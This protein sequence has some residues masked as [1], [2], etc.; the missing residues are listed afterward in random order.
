MCVCVC[1]R[2]RARAR[3]IN[4]TKWTVLLIS[5]GEFQVRWGDK[6]GGYGEHYWDYN[7]AGHVSVLNVTTVQLSF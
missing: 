4:R 7:H 3:A 6:H 5:A 1:V 2:A